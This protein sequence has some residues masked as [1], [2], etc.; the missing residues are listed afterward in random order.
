MR[1][2]FKHDPVRFNQRMLYPSSVF[3]LLPEDHECF[4]YDDIFKAC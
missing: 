2:P 3:D 4:V 1:V